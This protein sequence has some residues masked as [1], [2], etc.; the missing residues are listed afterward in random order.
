MTVGGRKSA[1]VPSSTPIDWDRLNPHPCV[2]CSFPRRYFVLV[3]VETSRFLRAMMGQLLAK[4]NSHLLARC[5]LWLRRSYAFLRGTARATR[6][7]FAEVSRDRRPTPAGKGK[8][9][10]ANR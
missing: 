6:E 4:L 10:D 8:T 2:L 9:F 7:T 3:R 5:P 1:R